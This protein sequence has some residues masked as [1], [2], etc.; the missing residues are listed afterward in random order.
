[1]SKTRPSVYAISALGLVASAGLAQSTF[2]WASPVDGDFEVA[3]NWLPAVVPGATDTAVL[4]GV[5]AYTVFAAVGDVGVIDLANPDATLQIVPGP[6]GSPTFAVGDVM[7]SGVLQIGTGVFGESARMNLRG[8]L[9][10][11]VVLPGRAVLYS[12]D[13]RLGPSAVI[14]GRGMVEG[15]WSGPG[16]LRIDGPG[17]LDLDVRFEGVTLHSSGGGTLNINRAVVTDATIESTADGA[18]VSGESTVVER[19]V[20]T[21]LYRVQPGNTINLGGGNVFEDGLHVDGGQVRVWDGQAFDSTVRLDAGSLVG[22]IGGVALLESGGLITGTG[23]VSAAWAGDGTIAIDEPGTLG[24]GGE[25]TGGTFRASNGGTLDLEGARLTGATIEVG[26]G[27]LFQTNTATSFTET[28]ILGQFR[29]RPDNQLTLGEGVVADDGIV[30]GDSSVIAIAELSV[31]PETA[32][33]APVILDGG[34]AGTRS[35]LRTLPS[36]RARIGTGGVVS[37]RGQLQGRWFLDGTLAPREG[38]QAGLIRLWV[39]TILSVEATGRVEMSIAGAD[40]SEFDRIVGAGPT[41]ELRLGGTLGVRFADGFE[42]AA[43]DRFEIVSVGTIEGEFAAVEIDPVAAVGPAHVVY[44][45]DAITVVVCAADRDGDGELT[46][47][48]FLEFQNQFDAGD[49]QAD[50]DADGALTIFDF[51]V[52]QNRFAAGCG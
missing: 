16:T 39:D 18:Y 48:D 47:F 34:I 51:L 33:N 49:A 17:L 20:F 10:A 29:V 35:V 45:G 6:S 3:A 46:I 25:C 5:G 8:L 31:L 2:R 15:T 1:M 7:G 44:S 50:L 21:G 9:D 26:D 11:T 40:E 24:F 41:P 32:I 12:G 23:S 4:G 19:C 37:G 27:G 30:V 42:P 52:F 14:S 36:R 43:G 38:S 22:P 13:A 28:T